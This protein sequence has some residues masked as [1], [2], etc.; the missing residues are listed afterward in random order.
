MNVF[1]FAASPAACIACLVL[2]YSVL[3]GTYRLQYHPLRHHPGPLF[4][5]LSGLYGAFYA[6]R[7]D[8]HLQTLKD[9]ALFGPVI[10]QGPNKLVFN[11]VR[12]LHDIYLNDQVT[13]SRAYLVTQRAPGVYGVFNA[14]DKQLH[15]AKRKLVG[16]VVNERS[17][18][19]LEPIISSQIDIFIQQLSLSRGS[20]SFNM[21]KMSRY[22]TMDI[23][24]H[25]AFSYPFNLQTD[26]THR[27]TTNTTNAN[28][29]L[30]IAMQLPFLADFRILMFS[31]LRALIRGKG[32]LTLLETAVKYRISQDHQ[33]TH[34]LLYMT[35]TMRDLDGDKINMDAIRNEA[36]FFLSA[37]SD[38]LSS[39]LSAV[40]HYLSVNQR[41]YQRLAHEIRS[42]FADGSEI[43][44][45]PRLASCQYLRAC[46]DE[47][48]RMCPPLPGT[49]W[50]QGVLNTVNSPLIVDG[51]YIAPGTEIGVNT[52]ALHHNAEYFPEPF[53]FKP[54][55]WLPGNAAA[56][57]TV[58]AAFTPFSIG[59]R[60]CVGKAMAYLEA[61][62]VV[63]KTMWYY[64]F[65]KVSGPMDV[66]EDRKDQEGA[67]YPI[68]DMLV[69]S[70]DGPYLCFHSRSG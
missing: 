10:R 53:I 2:V 56:S 23:M 29:L 31:C 30:N 37:G 69:A 28:Y 61:S 60:G 3:L 65:E 33:S 15:Q 7:T 18:R 47:A 49:L 25:I 44:S 51:H 9:H 48:L 67:V 26:A 52:Y 20:G 38:T 19:A 45:G 5:K 34:D 17:L 1:Q 39:T 14:I 58:K 54:E 4:A 42:T 36:I 62:L 13:K 40:F 16:K 70:H 12:A 8:L 35:D 22:L 55:R 57:T 11:S 43:H 46:I 6:R 32:Y 64:D 66:F 68:N 41:C 27:H 59:P 24:G 21:T 63:A 50:R